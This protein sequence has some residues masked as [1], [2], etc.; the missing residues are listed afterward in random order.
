MDTT[1]Y[2][3]PYLEKYIL[4]AYF[5]QND[6][7]KGIERMKKRYTAM[8]ESPIT[9]LWEGWE[10]GSAT[11]GGGTYNH[12]W[13]G[14][15]LT[16]MSQ[17]IAG[18]SPNTEGYKTFQIFPQPADLTAFKMGAA[19]VQGFAEVEWQRSG[20]TAI[21]TI[22]TPNCKGKIGIPKVFSVSKV[23]LKNKTIWEKSQ[24]S[25]PKTQNTEGVIFLEETA[26][27]LIF[28]VTKGVYTF[29]IK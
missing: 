29:E 18:L 21:L 27:Y 8:V 23:F 28:E 6:A 15:P 13:T 17:Y 11:Y 24:N 22:K 1:F 19:T 5:K 10:V 7:Q 9:T 16:L 14:G 12:G 4:E 26:D 2:A 3:G 25:K 20:N